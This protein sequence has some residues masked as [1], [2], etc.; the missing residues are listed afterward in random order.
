[1]DRR[2]WEAQVVALRLRSRVITYDLRAHGGSPAATEPY[3]AVDD[4]HVLMEE[5]GVRSADLIGLSS[6]ARVALDFA[7]THPMRVRSL[8][9]ASPGVSG[10]VNRDAMPWLEPVLRAA[11]SGDVL[12]AAELWA[13]TP[14]MRIAGDS[15]AAARVLRLSRDNRSLWSYAANPERPLSPPAL[16]R[17]QEVRVPVLV[18]AGERDLPE[19]RQLADTVARRITGARLHVIP[20]S[21]H[22]VNLAAPAAFN[23][24]LEAF[25]RE[26]SSSGSG[27]H[28]SASADATGHARLQR[29]L[30]PRGRRCCE[31]R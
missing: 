30:P 10:Y 19:L 13:A 25:L 17:L 22:M 18:V 29:P 28:G 14:L 15:L 16:G 23:A 7:L 4:L 11:R 9:L 21:G 31:Q 2:M 1:M 26:L 6:G 8:V 27:F 24:A 20:G 3:S 5:L 12:R